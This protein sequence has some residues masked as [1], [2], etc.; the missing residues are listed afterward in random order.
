MNPF[1]VEPLFTDGITYHVLKDDVFNPDPD[2]R[3]KDVFH[4][5]T[6]PKGT[7]FRLHEWTWEMGGQ[8]VKAKEITLA[9][10][11]RTDTYERVGAGQ[12]LFQVLLNAAEEVNATTHEWVIDQFPLLKGY[13]SRFVARLLDANVLSAPAL[14]AVYTQWENE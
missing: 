4:Q 5:P 1:A 11:G 13:G 12:A 3:K 14:R 7:R 10:G 6:I 2:R 8:D 9:P